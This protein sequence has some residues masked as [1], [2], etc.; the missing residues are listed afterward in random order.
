MR[1]LHWRRCSH[2]RPLEPQAAIE[3][4]MGAAMNMH[5]NFFFIVLYLL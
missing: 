5:I 4:V 2:R 1:R 3:S